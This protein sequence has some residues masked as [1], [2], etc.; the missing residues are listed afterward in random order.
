[1]SFRVSPATLGC[2]LLIMA[3]AAG[4]MAH[5][6]KDNG[7]PTS[8][9]ARGAFWSV[10]DQ[11]GRLVNLP[12]PSE[13]LRLEP[14]QLLFLEQ[15]EG[16]GRPL[17]SLGLTLRRAGRQSS[18][19]DLTL[20]EQAAGAYHIKLVP[21]DPVAAFVTLERSGGRYEELARTERQGWMPDPDGTFD[22]D[23][24]ISGDNMTL[25]LDGREL[26]AVSD[27]TLASGR[28]SVWADGID[29]LELRAKMEAEK[30]AASASAAEYTEDFATFAALPEDTDLLSAML[31]LGLS[32]VLACG[33]L[34]S[35]CA[36]PPPPGRL[37]DG[38]LRLLALPGLVLTV[39]LVR[40][41]SSVAL[42]TIVGIAACVGLIPALISLRTFLGSADDDGTPG[43]EARFQTHSSE[44]TSADWLRVGLV[45]VG[46]GLW[47][48][49]TA[50]MTRTEAIQP[51]LMR[52]LR[53]LTGLSEVGFELPAPVRLDTGNAIIVP[54]PYHGTLLEARVTLQ[55]DSLLE[56]RLRS[57]ERVA[58]GVALLLST[59]ARVASGWRVER[60][61]A[62]GPLGQP[63]PVLQPGRS[64][65]LYLTA[66]NNRFTARIDGNRFASAM[67]P[68]APSGAVV[69]LSPAG[70][71]QIDSL[72]VH[73]A[74]APPALLDIEAQGLRAA[75]TPV[76]GLALLMVLASHVLRRPFARVAE[77]L[78]YA[79][80]PIALACAQAEPAGH[81]S[82][83]VWIAG[84][85]GTLPL[86]LLPGLVLPSTVGKGRRALFLL[87]ATLAGPGALTA[88][89][90][91]PERADRA[92][93]PSFED[94]A[95]ARLN[96]GLIAFEHPLVRRFNTWLRDHRFRG[97]AVPIEHPAE[98]HRVLCIGS[99]STWG[100]S[101]PEGSGLAWPAQLERH[102]NSSDEVGAV[103]VI[104]GAIR[105]T[106]SGRMLFF[107]EEV[108]LQWRPD[109]IV[110][111]FGFNDASNLSILDDRATLLWFAEDDYHHGP[112][113]RFDTLWTRWEGEL[114]LRRLFNAEQEVQGETALSWQHFA[115]ELERLSPP[116]AFARNL[117]EM[118]T[119][120]E[121]IGADLILVKEPLREDAGYLWKKEFSRTVDRVGR[122]LGV[123]VVEPG[124]IMAGR[125]GASLFMD[126]VHLQPAGHRAMATILAPEVARVLS[127][128]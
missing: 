63:A 83:T 64:Y 57:Q 21:G 91:P 74:S 103:Q 9:Q 105:G 56:I 22:L 98:T 79:W 113:R 16:Q 8:R 42:G 11:S 53:S 107:L 104:N 67:E 38:A 117:L 88:T 106:T 97:R 84:A 95:G 58:E 70:S 111:N 2:A 112:L 60:D 85:A 120:A 24:T 94:F 37:L 116:D 30:Q 51:V 44:S 31:G 10:T 90:G 1:M 121:S 34:R 48:G 77:P 43:H 68:D 72:T 75:L 25:S 12:V 122:Q 27:D 28:T 36:A 19:I 110:V 6:D 86:L 101:L 54:G 108:L 45:L 39:A 13:G 115:A 17:E 89:L 35:L 126:L 23:I 33:W 118:G 102:L 125:G 92:D 32:L 46:L 99:S 40:D 47:V 78:A 5:L 59:D 114:L 20:R 4:L 87:L 55:P 15:G 49:L 127:E 65:A 119:L 52:Q 14:G 18:S 76:L 62:Y 61:A 41:V 128:R 71:A 123:P 26:L 69:L 3:G 66:T 7:A 80:V 50:A 100:H 124:P 109:V 82:W 73:P 29:V 81:L 96:E 93:G